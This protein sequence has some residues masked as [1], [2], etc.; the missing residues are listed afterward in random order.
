[1]P[2]FIKPDK[3]VNRNRVVFPEFDYLQRNL[4]SNN[5]RQAAHIRERTLYIPSDNLIAQLIYAMPLIEK[6]ETDGAFFER[7]KGLTDGKLAAFG[8]VHQGGYGHSHSGNIYSQI[9]EYY[10]HR[11]SDYSPESE[12][13]GISIISHPYIGNEVP[14]F[15]AVK[16]A[17]RI[18]RP[19]KRYAYFT[20][21]LPCLVLNY[22]KYVKAQT[23]KLKEGDTLANPIPRFIRDIVFPALV[24]QHT[25]IAF[26]NKLTQLIT[27][28]SY[29]QVDGMDG[30]SLPDYSRKTDDIIDDYFDHLTSQVT[31]LDQMLMLELPSGKMLWDVILERED[32]VV[33]TNWFYY[34]AN[35]H[36]Y[37]FIILMLAITGITTDNDEVG[38]FK[39]ELRMLSNFRSVLSHMDI[40]GKEAYGQVVKNLTNYIKDV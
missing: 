40:N 38:V 16:T 7:I 25:D 5:E 22:A 26:V 15:T 2:A 34:M 24:V 9:N 39:Y 13:V 33:T 27:G 20:I 17:H 18:S 1:M 21:D 23:A 37:A 19:E 12:A 8:L 36:Y 30:L 32:E 31:S 4:Q 35:Y 10:M 3:L 28:A 6:D 14:E 29:I 11:Y